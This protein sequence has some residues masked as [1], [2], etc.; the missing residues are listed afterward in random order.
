MK[1]KSEN[2]EKIDLELETKIENITFWR[3]INCGGLSKTQE[4]PEICEICG[5]GKKFEKMELK[6]KTSLASET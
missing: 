2:N 4:Q 3:C 6:I 5:E 1:N